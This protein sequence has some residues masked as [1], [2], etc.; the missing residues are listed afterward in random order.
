M[1]TKPKLLTITFDDGSTADFLF[2]AAKPSKVSQKPNTYA[3]GK[4]VKGDGTFQ[5]GC[6]A[7]FTAAE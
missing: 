2:G 1:K 5:V 6:N 4:A 7:T 3:G